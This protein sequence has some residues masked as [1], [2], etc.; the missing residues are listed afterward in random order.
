MENSFNPFANDQGEHQDFWPFWSTYQP[1]S[2]LTAAIP[3]NDALATALP[4]SQTDQT[5]SGF[6][7]L[8]HSFGSN[9]VFL[10]GSVDS[11]PRPEQGGLPR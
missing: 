7:M 9:S 11:E 2:T 10:N 5:S 4:F 1:N 6:S 8:D 3:F